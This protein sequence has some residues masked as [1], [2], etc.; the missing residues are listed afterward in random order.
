MKR[1]H[2]SSPRSPGGKKRATASV[3]STIR[4]LAGNSFVK[5]TSETAA[6]L[7]PLVD[8]RLLATGHAVFSVKCNGQ[9][10]P[11]TASLSQNMIIT[12]DDAESTPAQSISQ[13]KA[14][15]CSKHGVHNTTAPSMSVFHGRYSVHSLQTFHASGFDHRTKAGAAAF[16]IA[17]D[18]QMPD[19]DADDTPEVTDPSLTSSGS[20]YQLAIA[21]I[22]MRTF[23]Q[24]DND[25]Q[26]VAM[27]DIIASNDPAA[28]AAF[29]YLCSAGVP[30]LSRA[31]EEPYAVLAA[32]RHDHPSCRSLLVT[33]ASW[34]YD[35][36]TR[37]ITAP[38]QT[39]RSIIDARA[40][41]TFD[42]IHREAF[43]PSR[44]F[45]RRAS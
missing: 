23:R 21:A 8:S 28:P 42:S 7:Q 33:L 41:G 43:T 22:R 34:G 27:R 5:H 24:F 18:G 16:A 10:L 12:I 26:H 13:L 15:I 38:R 17:R 9:V 4:A 19:D 45:E 35:F 6:K 2:G 31:G 20:A 40:P 30:R 37:S 25:L 32:R 36:D 1:S 29:G 44:L 11:T 3:A 14:L 39:A